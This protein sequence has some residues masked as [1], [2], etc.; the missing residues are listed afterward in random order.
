MYPHW[1]LS[2]HSLFCCSVDRFDHM[3]S[4]VLQRQKDTLPLKVSFTEM[5]EKM[6]LWESLSLTQWFEEKKTTTNKRLDQRRFILF[7]FR[8]FSQVDNDTVDPLVLYLLL[9]QKKTSKTYKERERERSGPTSQQELHT[10]ER[11]NRIPS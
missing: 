4:S 11:N 8:N 9:Y 7:L 5:R 3:K 10:T 6:K 1:M 2:N